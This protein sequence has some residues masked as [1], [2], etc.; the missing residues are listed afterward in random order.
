MVKFKIFLFFYSYDEYIN[1]N[2]NNYRWGW[3]TKSDLL[4]EL[5]RYDEA[6]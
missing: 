4:K 5:E 2:P 3:D 1:L 6:L